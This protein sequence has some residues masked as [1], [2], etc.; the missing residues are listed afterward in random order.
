MVVV[1]GGVCGLSRGLCGEGQISRMQTGR[2]TM[3]AERQRLRSPHP[4]FL[5]D[6]NSGMDVEFTSGCDVQQILII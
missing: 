3:T 6:N 2:L 5:A 1:G 4:G